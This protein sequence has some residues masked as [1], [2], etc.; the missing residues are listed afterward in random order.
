MCVQSHRHAR[1]CLEYSSLTNV[2]FLVYS[3]TRMFRMDLDLNDGKGDYIGRGLG[4]YDVMSNSHGLDGKQIYPAHLSP[5]SKMQLRWLEPTELTT[6]R[7]TQSLLLLLL[8]LFVLCNARLFHRHL[9]NHQN[10]NIYCLVLSFPRSNRT[11]NTQYS[12]PKSRRTFTK[13]RT[14]FHRGNT[15]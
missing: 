12:R 4:D 8:L 7:V 3:R 10:A 14:T 1:A 13:Y 11:A 15:C 2:F 9:V 5:W 6:V